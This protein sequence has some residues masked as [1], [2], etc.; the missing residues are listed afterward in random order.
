MK[1]ALVIGGGPAGMMAAEELARAGAD[2]TL[3]E[4]KPTLARK[5][6]MAGKSGLN[7]TKQEPL[8]AFLSQY[9]HPQIAAIARAFG[10]DQMQQF[11]RDLDVDLF[12]GSTGRVF[13][14]VMKA[15]PML[16]AWIARLT[17]LG[18]TIRTRWRWQGWDEDAV[19]FD[20]PGGPAR[21]DDRGRD[22]PIRWRYGQ[23]P[24]GR[25]AARCG[26]DQ[27]AGGHPAQAGAA[28]RSG[29]RDHQ[30]PPSRWRGH[31]GPLW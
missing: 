28:Q 27:H 8:E 26:Q 30:A 31:G 22:G 3:I 29:V 13:P 23:D 11:A 12:T 15:S 1:T 19:L 14:K 7:L 24:H 9:S 6:L 20:T 4:A 2:V 25:R 5:F 10:P 17:E 18:V 16:R 21:R